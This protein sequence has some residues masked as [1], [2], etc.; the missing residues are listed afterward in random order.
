ML[1]AEGR[2]REGPREERAASSAYRP[3]HDALRGRAID[4]C[5]RD[6]IRQ[7]RAIIRTAPFAYEREHVRHLVDKL[8]DD[9]HGLAGWWTIRRCWVG[10]DQFGE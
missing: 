9:E 6:C 2:E 8:V 4:R 10:H 3:R 7:R 5:D 1:V